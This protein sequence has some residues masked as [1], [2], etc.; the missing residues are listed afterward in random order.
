MPRGRHSP[1][2]QP[3]GR[4]HGDD[5][6]SDDIPQGRHLA[7]RVIRVALWEYFSITFWTDVQ[8]QCGHSLGS[9]ISG[10]VYLHTAVAHT[11]L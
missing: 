5:R 8:G 9:V 3:V 10:S 1:G 4:Y 11:A 7:E 2:R 6:Q